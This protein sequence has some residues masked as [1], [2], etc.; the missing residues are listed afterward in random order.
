MPFRHRASLLAGLCII[1]LACASLPAAA[2]ESAALNGYVRD[3]ETGETLLQ[4]N[5]VVQGTS[6]GAATNNAGYY[7]LRDLAPRTYTIAFSYLGYRT[8]TEEVTL[9]PGETKRLDVELTPTDLQTDEVVVTGEQEGQMDQRV[10]VD[11]LQTATITQ[12]PSVLTPD[13]FRSLALLPGR[14]LGCRGC[15]S[16]PR[17]S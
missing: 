15:W 3:A 16:S 9:A 6:R 4:A 13:V 1:A 14:R 7:T 2:Q 10:G 17:R 11:Q 12:L 8:R 5:V